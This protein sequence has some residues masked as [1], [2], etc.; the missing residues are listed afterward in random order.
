MSCSCS[1]APLLHEDAYMSLVAAAP[2]SPMTGTFPDDTAAAVLFHQFSLVPTCA[3]QL[4]SGAQPSG[5]Q[6][7][8]WDSGFTEH[9][10]VSSAASERW[11]EP[12]PSGSLQWQTVGAP[13]QA[14]RLA[15]AEA[16]P[17]RTELLSRPRRRQPSLSAAPA[18][19]AGAEY[20][21]HQPAGRWGQAGGRQPAQQQGDGYNQA[22][23][24]GHAAATRQAGSLAAHSGEQPQLEGGEVEVPDMPG[25]SRAGLLNLRNKLRQQQRAT[26]HSPA[27][28]EAASVS[29]ATLSTAE[30]SR[31]PQQ[32]QA[33]QFSQP[34]SLQQPAS[35]NGRHLGSSSS[36]LQGN[37]ASAGLGQRHGAFAGGSAADAPNQDPAG[38]QVTLAGRLWCSWTSGVPRRYSGQLRPAA[39]RHLWA[40]IPPPGPGDPHTHLHQGLCQQ[41]QGLHLGRG[42]GGRH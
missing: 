10:S 14:F 9:G 6:R 32:Q 17:T 26:L 29:A 27:V 5:G 16:T 21:S 35:T 11:R 4:R 33:Q 37:A 40:H 39:V 3:L 22:S 23:A 20:A 41:A 31:Q 12:A 24:P 2:G 1:G 34:P 15:A 38:S 25:I 13:H 8:G 42:T 19:G 30:P 18:A 7:P 28:A 36:L